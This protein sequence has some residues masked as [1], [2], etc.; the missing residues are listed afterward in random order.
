MRDSMTVTTNSHSKASQV[1]HIYSLWC[2]A[3]NK[4]GK[5]PCPRLPGMPKNSNTFQVLRTCFNRG[6]QG[7]SLQM[8]EATT[9]KKNP[10]QYSRK[11]ETAVQK[12]HTEKDTQL[13][14][15]IFLDD[16]KHWI[17]YLELWIFIVT[18][19]SCDQKGKRE[20]L[21]G[22]PGCL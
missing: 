22:N 12:S 17:H 8:K 19:S 15:W 10:K 3:D 5:K 14:T 1:G 7:R 16:R 21:E 20:H 9:W 2:R 18:L 11:P 4:W 13:V 6:P